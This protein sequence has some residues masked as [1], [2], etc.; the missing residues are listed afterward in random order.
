MPNESDKE[1]ANRMNM[2]L[3]K[4]VSNCPEKKNAISQRFN[5]L[6]FKITNIPVKGI[7]EQ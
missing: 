4:N 2:E 6:H 7:Y 3:F 1:L 5:Q